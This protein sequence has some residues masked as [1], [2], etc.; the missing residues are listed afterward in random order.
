[1]NLLLL[2]TFAL[3][4][5]F[6]LD[7]DTLSLQCKNSS[8]ILQK[9][10][11]KYDKNDQWEQAELK[12]HIQEPRVGNPKR[13]S[14]VVLDN[15]TRYFEIEREVEGTSVKW[16][17][18]GK[19]QF[20]AFLN[21]CSIFSSEIADRYGLNKERGEGFHKFY[22]TLYGL[23]MS[24]RP[25]F[26]RTMAPAE[27]IVFAGRNA[28]SIAVELNQKLISKHWNLIISAED[29]SLLAVELLN[30]DDPESGE[31]IKFEEAFEVD[32][33]LLPRIRHW[34]ARQSNE[35]HGSDIIVEA[36]E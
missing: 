1:M 6:P 23:P 24:V 5:I 18:E 30:P 3:P 21:G 14:R 4:S 36:I 15:H 31:I 34:Y 7:K 12:L 11:N 26:F 25:E 22:Q 10:Q 28:H 2:L 17:V 19:G 16:V 20:S 13:Y 27:A 9:S 8:Y 32:S 33:I 35:Y 29:H